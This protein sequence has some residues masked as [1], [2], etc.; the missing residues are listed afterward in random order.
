MFF[1]KQRLFASL[2]AI[3]MLSTVAQAQTGEPA[4]LQ[5]AQTPKLDPAV[6]KA[7]APP[8]Q[9]PATTAAPKPANGI[10]KAPAPTPAEIKKM[11]DLL[12][13][14][15]AQSK[16]ISSLYVKYVRVDND[17]MFN[18]SKKYEGQAMLHKPDLVFLDFYEVATGKPNTLDERI[19]CDGKSV[20]QFKGATKQIWVYPL[21]KNQQEK[22]LNQG[23]LPFLFDMTVEKAKNRYQMIYRGENETSFIIQ[24]IPLLEIDRAEYGLAMVQLSKDRLLPMAI[25]LTSPNGKETKLFT[26]LPDQTIANGPLKPA[27]FDGAAMTASL[28]KDKWKVIINPDAEG[29]PQVQPGPA[30]GPAVGARPAPRVGNRPAPPTNGQGGVRQK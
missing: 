10:P 20:Y 25:K 21:P 2:A 5:V 7:S 29:R 27:F 14:W 15:E 30:Q 19:V 4:R 18:V 28:A 24:I 12:K 6:V 11:E 26:F 17:T 23:A 1:P 3:L 16:S 13:R 8:Q 22:A 9:K